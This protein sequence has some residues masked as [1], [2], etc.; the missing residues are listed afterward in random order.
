MC[1]RGV[2]FFWHDGLTAVETP[3]VLARRIVEGRD[4]NPRRWNQALAEDVDEIE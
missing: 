1:R 3:K 2:R 4:E